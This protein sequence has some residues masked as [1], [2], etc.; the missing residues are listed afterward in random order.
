[1]CEKIE[2]TL[3]RSASRRADFDMPGRHSSTPYRTK[4]NFFSVSY[5]W[6]ELKGA[7]FSVLSSVRHG[8]RRL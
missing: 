5:F 6:D 1:M 3:L 8:E 7:M 4:L 2:M